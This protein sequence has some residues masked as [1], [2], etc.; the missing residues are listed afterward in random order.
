[1]TVNGAA[2]HAKVA[3]FACLFPTQSAQIW[4]YTSSLR[5]SCAK[6][7]PIGS[8]RIPGVI[9]QR[10]ELPARAVDVKPA[11]SIGA[12]LESLKT[13]SERLCSST[14]MII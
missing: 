12:T 14:G 13:N 2:L 1:M 10:V 6:F 4:N 7:S 11:N 9:N 5:E 8:R 3:K